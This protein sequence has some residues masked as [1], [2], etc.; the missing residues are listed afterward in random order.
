MPDLVKRAAG[1]SNDKNSFQVI[2]RGTL[3]TC[4]VK[5]DKMITRVEV[6]SRDASQVTKVIALL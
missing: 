4:S 3:S 6:R 2:G 5:G 1:G